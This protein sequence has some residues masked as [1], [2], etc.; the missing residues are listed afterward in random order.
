M[1]E[2]WGRVGGLI[3]PAVAARMLNRSKGRITQMMTAGKLQKFVFPDEN[4]VF[5]SWLEVRNMAEQQI[6][7]R[8]KRLMHAEIKKSDL[9][10]EQKEAFKKIADQSLQEALFPTG[11]KSS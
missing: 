3:T 11:K 10:P 1:L 6:L 2:T 9:T 7:A 4:L 5:V 8:Q